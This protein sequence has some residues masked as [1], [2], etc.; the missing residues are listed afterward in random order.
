MAILV[1]VESADGKIKKTS[2]EAV[3]YAHAMGGPVTAVVLGEVEKPELE[4]IGKYGA[5]KVL[6]VADKRLNQGV[7]QAYASVLAQ[8]ME[9]EGADTLVLANSSLGTPVAANRSSMARQRTRGPNTDCP[10]ADAHAASAAVSRSW[11]GSP[12]MLW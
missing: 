1:F 11:I 4:A 7:I 2:L 9:A 3:A 10:A 5:A 8:A 6:S 12:G